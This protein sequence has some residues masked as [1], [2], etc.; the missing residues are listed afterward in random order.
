LRNIDECSS[1]LALIEKNVT[2]WHLQKGWGSQEI[3]SD[4]DKSLSLFTRFII[5][6][7][8]EQWQFFAAYVPPTFLNE[9]YTRI[10]IC[11]PL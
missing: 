7:L 1:Q 4:R 9:T 2:F 5:T 6:V 10:Q 3:K 8:F 11:T